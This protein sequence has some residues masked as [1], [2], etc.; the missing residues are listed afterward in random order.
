MSPA[1]RCHERSERRRLSG[2]CVCHRVAALC[3]LALVADLAIVTAAGAEG[4]ERWRVVRETDGIELSRRE[5]DATAFRAVAVVE[6]SLPQVLAVLRDVPRHVEWR[7]RCVESRVLSRES[8]KVAI[9]YNRIDGIWPIAD[10]DVVIRSVTRVD[11]PDAARIDLHVADSPLAP[12]PDGAVRMP[13]LDG[14]YALRA[15]GPARTRVEYRMKL[16]L[17][18]AVPAW[19]TRFASEDMPIATLTG[20]RRQVAKMQ[21]AYDAFVRAWPQAAAQGEIPATR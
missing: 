21:G 15:E 1:D 19:I 2:P 9:L 16:S 18:G 17:G 11:G 6:A 8:P 3:V 10:R 5:D 7:S 4:G 14:S 20:L 12:D 13:Q